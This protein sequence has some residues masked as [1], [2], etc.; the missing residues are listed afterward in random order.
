MDCSKDVAV[1]GVLTLET[2]LGPGVRYFLLVLKL[3]LFFYY[4]VLNISCRFT[5]I[6]TQVFM[7]S[8]PKQVLWVN[9]HIS[10]NL[11]ATYFSFRLSYYSKART[12][13]QSAF[14]HLARR[15]VAAKFTVVMP[16]T[17]VVGRGSDHNKPFPLPHLSPYFWIQVTRAQ[18]LRSKTTSGANTACV[19]ESKMQTT[20]S[21]FEPV[22]Y[23][24][25]RMSLFL[26]VLFRLK[27]LCNQ[28]VRSAN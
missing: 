18:Y 25:A 10:W 7:D 16:T 23:L 6:R 4:G 27:L 19:L 12:A 13:L 1:C 5:N 17:M 22:H 26:R 21:V 24:P 28:Q 9:I 3:L 2:G 20:F 14:I 11:F 8:G 15:H